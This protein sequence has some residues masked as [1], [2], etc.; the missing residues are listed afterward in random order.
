[1]R[2]VST[3]SRLESLLSLVSLQAAGEAQEDSRPCAA[4]ETMSPQRGWSR[5]AGDGDRGSWG[6]A[7][8]P[9]LPLICT[10][11][12]GRYTSDRIFRFLMFPKIPGRFAGN[13]HLQKQNKS[14]TLQDAEG[15]GEVRGALLSPLPLFHLFLFAEGEEDVA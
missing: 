3:C 11:S 6:G 7:L 13:G 1:M 12:P 14:R 9:V 10:G 5:Q 2:A 4:L 15:G 8:V